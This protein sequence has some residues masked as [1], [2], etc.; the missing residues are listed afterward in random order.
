MKDTLNDTLALYNYLFSA[1]FKEDDYWWIKEII[2]NPK[3]LRDLIGEKIKIYDLDWIYISYH[4]K[5][6]E[7]FIR[8]FKDK[9]DWKY[10]SRFQELSEEFIREFKDRVNWE[11]ISVFQILSEGFR[12][13]FRN[14][15]KE[16]N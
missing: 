13:E 14:V 8:E 5:L 15:I 3:Q 10:I 4:Q 7:G 11:Y 16:R 12:E 1:D 2:N 9:V 6:S